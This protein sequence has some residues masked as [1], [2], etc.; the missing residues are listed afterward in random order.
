MRRRSLSLL[1][2]SFT[3][4]LLTT[5]C[6][7]PALAASTGRSDTVV[8]RNLGHGKAALVVFASSASS[9]TPTTE[10]SGA[11]RPAPDWPPAASTA[12]PTTRPWC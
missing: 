11:L 2:L 4:L 12:P 8:L 6:A 1:V 10:W 9:L 7:A 3:V 5:V